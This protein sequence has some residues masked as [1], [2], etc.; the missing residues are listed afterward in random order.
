MLRHQR[1]SVI[2]LFAWH[3]LILVG[4]C[5]AIVLQKDIQ[6]WQLDQ[7]FHPG[8]R[9]I[10][11]HVA[12]L[13][14]IYITG[15]VLA[16]LRATVNDHAGPLDFWIV[17]LALCGLVL[18]GLFLLRI[19][20]SRF[21]VGV[22]FA[23]TIFLAPA[24]YFIPRP[25]QPSALVT[26]MV[27]L[28]C[29][30]AV[31]ISERLGSLIPIKLAA[32][33]Q[34]RSIKTEYYIL[35]ERID[36]ELIPKPRI[37][38]GGLARIG[39]DVI[40]STGD[41]QLYYVELAGDSA[42]PR[43]RL[44]PYHV[45]INGDAFARADGQTGVSSPPVDTTP[46]EGNAEIERLHPEWFRVSDLLVQELGQRIRIFASHLFWYAKDSCWVERV[47]LLEGYQQ[48][49]TEGSGT[50]HWK[51]LFES[52]PCLSAKGP[53][54]R[55]GIPV[56]GYMGGGRMALLDDEHLLLTVGD[57]GFDGV[58]SPWAVSQDLTNSYGKTLKIDI[59]DGASK[60]FTSGHRNQQG[61]FVGS[62]G[63]IWSTEHGPKGGDELNA[64]L[65][66]SN[67]GW[68]NATYG[69]DYGSYHWPRATVEGEHTGYRLPM[70]SWVPSIGTSAVIEV[71]EGLFPAWRHDLLVSSLREATLFRIRIRSDRVI[72]TEPIPLGC[73]VRDFVEASD[74]K[75]VI[76]SDSCGLV[77]LQPQAI[78]TGESL[79][80]EW[81]SG[82]HQSQLVSGNR[83]GPNLVGIINRPVASLPGYTDY[84]VSLKAKGGKWS[85]ERLDQFISSPAAFA[86]GTTMDFAGVP[87]QSD[88]IAIMRFLEE[89]H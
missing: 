89:T 75:L 37:K 85:R 17:S 44:L 74:G 15:A 88:R 46:V 18:L 1:P 65:E 26:I 58:A 20:A 21:A 13:A 30:G 4:I 81:C 49:L 53:N 6:L 51:T 77:L 68:P 64:L 47:S 10:I 7:L 36:R 56:V 55:H 2:F 69:T 25:F 78:K 34:T 38:G 40:V 39:A 87:S 82:C 12:V 50:E 80:N 19:D 31:S 43:V 35:E 3:I 5:L 22:A 8:A 83:I 32:T 11:L 76:W 67:Y 72:Y 62:D 28:L 27:V 59:K 9:R 61:L 73:S 24:P 33:S 42:Q 52:T 70:F 63:R 45:P 54:R 29:A 41:G 57:F 48:A 66:G 79:F 23:S 14:A 16:K 71:Q 60:I 84:S 86:S